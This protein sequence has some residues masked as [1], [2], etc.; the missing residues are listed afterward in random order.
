[1]DLQLRKFKS[2]WDSKAYLLKP[3]LANTLEGLIF[4]I[5][6]LL[7]EL[8]IAEKDKMGHFLLREES[9]E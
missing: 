1:M 7:D 9:A 4:V 3:H 2:S 5:I 8:S 6:I